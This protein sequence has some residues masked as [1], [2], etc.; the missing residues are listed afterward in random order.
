[1]ERLIVRVCYNKN[2]GQKYITIPQKNNLKPGDYV[3]I[4]KVT[5]IKRCDNDSKEQEPSQ[6]KEL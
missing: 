4:I 3:E 1:M 2:N 5:I 6:E